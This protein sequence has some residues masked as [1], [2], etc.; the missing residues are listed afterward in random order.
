MKCL[1]LIKPSNTPNI[2]HLYEHI[3]VGTVDNLFIKNKLYRYIDYHIDAR[4]YLSGMV[5][6]EILFYSDKAVTLSDEILR[7]EPKFNEDSIDGSLWQIMAEKQCSIFSK[8]DKI[9]EQL[10]LMQKY[11]WQTMDELATLDILDNRKAAIDFECTPTA[12]RNFKRLKCE[13]ILETTF[14]KQN[15][16]LTVLF[17]VLSYVLTDNISVMLSD[18]FYYFGTGNSCIYSNKVTKGVAN[19]IRH[20]E[21]NPQLTDELLACKD[22]IKDMFANG[23]LERMVS[24]LQ[25]STYKEPHKTPDE[26]KLYEATGILIGPRGWRAIATKQNIDNIINS[27]TLKLTYGKEIQKTKLA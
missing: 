24:F 20:R 4:A 18:D 10:K 6:I 3:F 1:I 15:P 9:K 19:F 2:A 16:K 8:N 13:I 21:Q 11:P 27:T 22:C 14:A 17:T 5:Y 26:I 23:V 7:L 12:K 25:A